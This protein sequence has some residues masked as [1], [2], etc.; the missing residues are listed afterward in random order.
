MFHRAALITSVVAA[1]TLSA[2]VQPQQ[3]AS[4]SLPITGCDAQPAQFA[5]GYTSTDALATEVRNRS[6]AYQVRVLR[7]EQAVT[8]EYSEQRINLEVDA[9]NRVTRVHCG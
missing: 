9:G 1:A 5:V 4:V 7:P 2:C 8:L 3:V 6:G